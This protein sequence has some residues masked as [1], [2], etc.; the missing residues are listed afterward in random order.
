MKGKQLLF[1]GVILILLLV[2]WIAA[3]QASRSTEVLDAQTE[4]WEK[5]NGFSEKELYVRAIPY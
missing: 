4:L 2:G 3:V 5:A 1:A